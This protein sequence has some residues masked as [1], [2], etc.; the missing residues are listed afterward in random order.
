VPGIKGLVQREVQRERMWPT[1]AARKETAASAL[2]RG[3]AETIKLEQ[4][5]NIGT[6]GTVIEACR[7]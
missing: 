6:G 3:V 5:K 7:H 1:T 2:D 4:D